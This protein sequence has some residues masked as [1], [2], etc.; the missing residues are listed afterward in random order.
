MATGTLRIGNIILDADMNLPSG[1]KWAMPVGFIYMQLP[2]KP[3]PSAIF[4]GTWANISSTFAGEFFRIEG[5]NA[6]VF[7]WKGTVSS[8]STTVISFTVAHG[9]SVG[10]HIKNSSGNVRIVSVVNS[11]VQVTVSVAFSVAP[12]GIMYFSQRDAIRNITGTTS[13]YQTNYNYGGGGYSGAFTANVLSGATDGSSGTDTCA[14]N[15]FDASLVVPTASDNRPLNST[16]RIW[17]RT[18]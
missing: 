13:Y 15:V 8:S 3:L 10:D 11:I 6:S 14:R 2:T 4:T 9:L 5:D 17:E 7:E 16:I 18:A 1:S 12:T